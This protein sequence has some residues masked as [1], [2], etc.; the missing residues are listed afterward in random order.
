MKTISRRL[1][2][3]LVATSFVLSAALPIFPPMAMAA[4]P[5]PLLINCQ[6]RLHDG[7]D[8]MNGNVKMTLR[9]FNQLSGGAPMYEDSANV[10]VVDGLYST[11]LGDDT[12]RGNLLEALGAGE[13][14]LEVTAGGT[15]FAPRERMVTVPYAVIAKAVVREGITEEMVSQGAVVERHLGKGSI[16]A[17]KLAV[18]SV[19]AEKILNG[20]ITPEKF[21]NVPWST[22]GNA[23]Q[24]GKILVL[25][26]LD[27]TPLDISV[28]GRRAIRI[29][30]HVLTASIVGGHPSNEV[31]K[32]A[33]GA[34][35]AG[36]GTA[37]APN[38]ANGDFVFI[39]SGEGNEANGAHSAIGGG[40]DNK[41]TGNR[42][43][44]GGGRNNQANLAGGA[45]G[46]GYS[47]VVNNTYAT[48]AGGFNNLAEGYASSVGGGWAN[49]ATGEVANVG[50][51]MQNRAMA[52]ASSVGGGFQN[53]AAGYGARVGGGQNN[54]AIGDFSFV[55]G[56]TNNVARG[57][58]SAI[59]AGS[60]NEALADY[61]IAA[62]R[63]A[64][65]MHPNSFVFS[66]GQK[67]Q[68]ASSAANQVLLRASG[69]VGIGTSTPSEQLEVVGNV[70]ADSIIAKSF[71]GDGSNL[72]GIQQGLQPNSIQP[73]HLADGFV[74]PADKIQGGALTRNAA[75][76]GVLQGTLD[77]AQLVPGS[78]TRDMLA[79][80]ARTI[81]P[82][83]I[84][85]AQ[86]ADGV[87]PVVPDLAGLADAIEES[88][89]DVWKLGGNANVQ[90]GK[91]FIGTTDNSP[92][93]LRANNLGALWL[94]PV[95]DGVG[96]AAGASVASVHKNSFVFSGDPNAPASTTRD[97]QVLLMA[98]N[99]VGINTDNPSEA[100]TVGGT[101]K[102]DGFVGDGS[103]LTNLPIPALPENLLT[104][105]SN[106]E[107]DV[108]GP[109]AA[110]KLR[111]GI[112]GLD[113]LT[114]ELRTQI[115]AGATKAAAEAMVAEVDT[116]RGEIDTKL[117]A[118]DAAVDQRIAESAALNAQTLLKQVDTRIS[119]ATQAATATFEAGDS[120]LGKVDEKIALAQNQMDERIVM[121]QQAGQKDMLE[122]LNERV[123]EVA[124]QATATGPELMA[125]VDQKIGA[126]DAKV[127][128]ALQAATEAA[129]IAK[130]EAS[131]VL[132]QVDQK[133]GAIDQKIGAVDAKADGAMEAAMAAKTSAAGVI[134]QVD[135]KIETAQSQ[136]DERIVLV[137]Q[138]SQKEL[139]A[140]MNERV[141]AV[142]QQAT[143]TGPELM[144]Q[145]DQ[146]IG[147]VN[148]RFGSVDQKISTVD[149]K[150]DGALQAATEAKSAATGL[151]GQVDAKIGAAQTQMDERIVLVQQASQKDLL[152][153]MNERVAAVAQ[154]AT[155][156][157][158]ELMAQVDQK[159]ATVDRKADG[160]LQAAMEAKTTAAGVSGQVD[161]KI[162][163]A[164]T[165]MD[166]R[167][168][169]V[170]QAAQKD[171]LAQMNE[172]VAAVAQQAT[173][174][175]PELMAQVDQKIA[176][177]DRKADGALQAAMEAKTTA[178]GVSGQV[179][180]KIEAAQ[181]QM[182]ER[183][184]L[185][186]QAA[187]KDLLAQMNARV[188]AVAQQ[189]TATGPE[190]MAQVDQ[191][192]GAVDAKVST[193]MQA[194]NEASG[195][196]ANAQSI[197]A[198]VLG[199][200]D[201]K[202][203]ANQAAATQGLLGTV[204]SKIKA[205]QNQMDE[206]IILVQEASQKELLAK[207]N[208]R[209]AQVAQQ[210]SATGPQVLAQVDQK[211]N[212]KLALVDQKV[213]AAD[214]A[215]RSASTK[216]GDLLAQV[217]QRI[218]ANTQGVLGTVDEKLALA[219][220]QM[221]ER[222]VLVQDASQKDMLN[223]IDQ[224]IA[225]VAAQAK[226]T[227]PEIL[228]Q[229]NQKL[230]LVDQQVAGAQAVANSLSLEV[231]GKIATGQASLAQSILGQVDSKIA[232]AQ[233]QADERVIALQNANAKELL[234]QVNNIVDQKVAV[235]N[236][237]VSASVG[238]Q[239]AANKGTSG[240][241]V[242]A[243][244]DQKI[245]VAKNQ[246]DA[247]ILDVQSAAGTDLLAS[248]DRKIAGISAGIPNTTD[249]LG[250]VDQRI[251][252]SQVRA[253]QDLLAQVDQKLGQATANLP[254]SAALM[255]Q[256]DQ[257][258]AGATADL[259]NT[260][261]LLAQVNEKVATAAAAVAPPA[262]LLQQVDLR[263]DAASTRNRQ[264]MLAAVDQRLATATTK[265]ASA[266]DTA[267][268]NQTIAQSISDA[269]ARN[270]Q[271]ILSQLSAQVDSK[272]ASARPAL[273]S[274][275][276]VQDATDGPNVILG[277][278]A[279]E[280]GGG[281]S[282]SVIAGGG[283]KTRPN[284]ITS[285]YSTISGG[286]GNS[287]SALTSTIGGGEKNTAQGI[288]STIGG[289]N[290]NQTSGEFASIGGGAAN[291]AF[292]KF[293]TVGGGYGNQATGTGAT[294][295]GGEKNEA[296][297]DFSVAAGRNARALHPG[298]I[299]L[300]DSGD[301]PVASSA[302]NQ[303]IARASGGTFIFSSASSGVSLPP[304]AGSW[305]NLS[306]RHAKKDFE[307]VDA[308]EVLAKV[309]ALPIYKY[310]YKSQDGVPH[311]GP[312]AQDFSAAFALG[313]DNRHINTLDADG[314][315]LAAIQGLSQ[316]LSERDAQVE[317]LEKQ[318]LILAESLQKLLDK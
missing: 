237:Q 67:G 217:D 62:G 153:Q 162:E 93:E 294:V 42:S 181:S 299:V 298:S 249:L 252:A 143:A 16:S 156:T 57:A 36:G 191:K 135:A 21:A 161:A 269:Q 30:P 89:S 234:D 302:A 163:A 169:L 281:V 300:A 221:D 243:Q 171:L 84:T 40:W 96:I 152:A 266:P 284:R 212:E 59:P 86:L 307:T 70:K 90:P 60:D 173:A 114:P 149:S 267:M 150:A 43:F 99:N 261:A 124:Q 85:A 165:Q 264:D 276:R 238:A 31:G 129:T 87:I 74:L 142:A 295:I 48:V 110:L 122:K 193:A 69:G 245:A 304:G 148:Q 308:R 240:P 111:T 312:V 250:Q 175:G 219:Q 94:V 251:S 34:V 97:G 224:R 186:Q 180:A 158:P 7:D 316:R 83:S 109:A 209:V 182:D 23:G 115:E 4:D 81:D 139:I 314:V 58:G 104:A 137:Q 227:G 33:G 26:T 228:A 172:R 103:G 231:D 199:Q 168:V 160:A 206:R 155:A 15:T 297:G 218:A 18:D 311:M 223:T 112:V 6:G 260:A 53:T 27:N 213:A 54:S 80:D 305:N 79:A 184:L 315:A 159:I 10:E 82:G 8:L 45:I 230:S 121:V 14:Y 127:D 133:L 263:I 310:Q 253:N 247:R 2:A 285:N 5:L 3:A 265:F 118:A 141:A 220:A 76:G 226:A 72:T 65:A 77:Q 144:A 13:A 24:D 274:G 64:V 119:S 68:F 95:E 309:E 244:V 20:T 88:V 108:T 113:H 203:A 188:A 290:A 146:K 255:A 157:G 286:Q 283:A 91:E 268:M 71:I 202:I 303:L 131:G 232:T 154:Q 147:E 164:Q 196:A 292:G 272:I 192:F 280:I 56:G 279:N 37:D 167:I 233:V 208:E 214:A 101:V 116:L 216:S 92:I 291:K 198:G 125:Q 1:L 246:M 177:V 46:G 270:N 241:E 194:A 123:A 317:M 288:G 296:A 256:V 61:A 293:S 41:T 257:K 215:A 51:G 132:E 19:T 278:S 78:I 102:A 301:S 38:R 190:L 49:A 44:I 200:V 273:P 306:D 222:I 126:V 9:I 289:G 170:Q 195:A 29:L 287:A 258:I 275:I 63:G 136:M 201:Q 134:G 235:A 107:G 73:Q 262:D 211:L 205:A 138:A 75:L 254:S 271:Q 189:A 39:G 313:Q 120:L 98:P 204:D 106:F 55:G 318:V 145:V 183:I 35:V 248:V 22:S 236:Q 25:G 17:D 239:I 50:G 176:T 66:D 185:V 178:A 187:Q 130:T 259:P 11:F 100:L 140:Q 207:M 47:N 166:E 151:L 210:A 277:N 242:L 197:A 28:A 174:T 229:M 105:G 128:G 179:D 12:T 32:G 225:N 282:S 52:D 117:T